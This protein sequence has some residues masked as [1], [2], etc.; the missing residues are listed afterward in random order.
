M[1]KVNAP[2]K[3]AQFPVTSRPRPVEN[4]NELTMLAGLRVLDLITA[5]KPRR[6][7]LLPSPGRD[8]G[9]GIPCRALTACRRLRHIRLLRDSDWVDRRD[10]QWPLDLTILVIPL[11]IAIRLCENSG[12]CAGKT[13]RP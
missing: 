10:P 6:R 5:S 4:V 12:S 13:T 3:S 7:V 2:R 8:V 11:W 9:P 1:A